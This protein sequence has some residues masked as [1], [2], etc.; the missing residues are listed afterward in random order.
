MLEKTWHFLNSK[1]I[2]DLGLDFEEVELRRDRDGPNKISNIKQMS[3]LECFASQF[4][5]PIIYILIVAAS[6]TTLLREWVDSS[7]I[8]AVVILISVLSVMRFNVVF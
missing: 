3:N 5:Q 4:K 2:F 7:V 8:F 6:I 1:E